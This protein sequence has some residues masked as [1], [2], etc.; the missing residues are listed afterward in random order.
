LQDTS[1]NYLAYGG[2]IATGTSP[3]GTRPRA[4][5]DVAEVATGRPPPDGVPG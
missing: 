2:K 1:Y 4:A 5:M 3:N